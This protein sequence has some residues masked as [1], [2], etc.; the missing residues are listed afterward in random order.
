MLNK[1]RDKL[2]F[3]REPIRYLV[4]LALAAYVAYQ[5]LAE[6]RVPE[7]VLVE[8]SPAL[9]FVA[10]LAELLRMNVFSPKSVEDREQADLDNFEEVHAD[11]EE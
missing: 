6:G 3:H 11:H 4:G 7:E 5:L 10:A 2:R 1:L 9:A 8:D